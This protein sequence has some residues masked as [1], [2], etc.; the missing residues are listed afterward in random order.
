MKSVAEHLEHFLGNIVY[1]WADPSSTT[2][3]QI[4]SF[5]NQP[6]Q[7]VLTYSTLGLSEIELSLPRGRTIRQELV[8][9]AHAS[10]SGEEIANFLMGCAEYL[11]NGVQSGP[12]WRSH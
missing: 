10:F 4:V 9:S 12:S 3:V 5:E 2:N 8:M 6:I 1:G 7:G 11:S